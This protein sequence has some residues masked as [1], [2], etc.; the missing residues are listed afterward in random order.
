MKIT[1]HFTDQSWHVPDLCRSLD[2]FPMGSFFIITS[3]QRKLLLVP[4]LAQSLNGLRA[5]HQNSPHLKSK[6]TQQ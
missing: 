2:A 5:L 4:A 6:I 1:C 3:L